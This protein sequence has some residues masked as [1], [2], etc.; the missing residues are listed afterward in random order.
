MLVALTD[1]ETGGL[2]PESDEIL[3]IAVII[4]DSK[5]FEIKDTWETKVK[6]LYPEN[7]DPKA[8]AVNGYCEEEWT[9]AIDIIPALQEFVERTA[10]CVFCSYNIH[11]DYSFIEHA[12][13]KYGIENKFNYQKFC[14]MSM[15]FGKI[16]HSKVQS[17]SLKTVSTLLNVPREPKIHRAMGGCK[18]EYDLYC[19]LM[20]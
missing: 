8:I 20:K 11:F 7:I 14:L 18:N 9:E 12:L 1:L 15:A 19:A 5:T 2:D 6:P 17:W 4:F 3:E 13:K 10:G 16:D